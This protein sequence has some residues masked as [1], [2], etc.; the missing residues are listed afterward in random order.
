ME[1]NLEAIP[2]ARRASLSHSLVAGRNGGLVQSNVAK[3]PISA[4]R[5]GGMLRASIAGGDER[6][7]NRK[8]VGVFDVGV[9]SGMAV[10]SIPAAVAE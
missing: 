4:M 3:P 2:F 10:L 9:F 1:V 8:N 6:S 5:Q 7:C